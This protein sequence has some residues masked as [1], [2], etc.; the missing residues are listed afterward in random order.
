MP[1][2]RAARDL[3]GGGWQGE[4]TGPKGGTIKKIFHDRNVTDI[5]RAGGRALGRRDVQQ[6][7]YSRVG[8]EWAHR[9]SVIF[10]KKE[11]GGT[12][13]LLFDPFY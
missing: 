3:R 4:I 11:K 5:W 9:P 10:R 1:K 6:K 8:V 7:E 12:A 2:R 13:L